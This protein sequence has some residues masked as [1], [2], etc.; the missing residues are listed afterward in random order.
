LSKKSIIILIIAASFSLLTFQNCSRAK[1]NPV[2]EKETDQASTEPSAQSNEKVALQLNLSH[3]PGQRQFMVNTLGLAIED[4]NCVIQYEKNNSVWTD[5]TNEFPC[6]TDIQDGAFLL[7]AT[8]F[9]TN[10]FNSTGVRLRLIRADDDSVLG[11]FPQKLTCVSSA[12]STVLT[13]NKDEN[14]NGRWDDVIVGANKTCEFDSGSIIYGTSYSC[15]ASR[16]C[17]GKTALFKEHIWTHMTY[18]YTTPACDPREIVSLAGLYKPTQR[19]ATLTGITPTFIDSGCVN[20]G[21]G[22]YFL[23][24]PG[25]WLQAQCSY[26][27]KED[28]SYF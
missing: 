27:Y 24:N 26:S 4:S 14:C 23:F 1:F 17:G 11:L 12:P 20:T 25:A 15:P 22:T 3:S 13:P 5:A 10:N 21:T 18:H 9:W 6:N 7:P 19:S 28:N 16:I 8:D 2:P